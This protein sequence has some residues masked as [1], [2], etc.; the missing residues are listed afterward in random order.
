M[1]FRLLLVLLLVSA[2]ATVLGH[3]AGSTVSD[4]PTPSASRTAAQEAK[5]LILGVAET[6]WSV[7]LDGE[8]ALVG[9]T[10]FSN[11][12]VVA[13]YDRDSGPGQ[14]QLIVG[15]EPSDLGTGRFANS[16]SL[17]GDRALVGAPFNAA[18]GTASGAAYVFERDPVSGLWSQVVQLFSDDIGPGDIFGRS[19]SLLGD[20]ALIGADG[21]GAAYIF[22]R[23]PNTGV[24]SQTDKLVAADATSGDRFGWSV[25]LSGDRALVG[26]FDSIS[27]GN[28]GAAY[29]F[30]RDTGTG[31]WPQSA[32][33]VAGDAGSADR[34]G[35][36]VSL[37]GDR[38]L[39]G[40]YLDDDAGDRSGSAY[41]FDRDAGS[42]LWSQTDKLT[43]NDSAARDEFGYSVSLSGDRALVGAPVDDFS[44]GA[45]YLFG[46]D[47]ATGLWPQSAKLLVADGEFG[48]NFGWS[49]SVSGSRA[50]I[51]AVGDNNDSGSAYI[52]ILPTFSVGGMISGLS[53]SGLMLQNSGVDDLPVTAVGAFTFP[54]L[55][56]D[57]QAYDVSVVSQPT[58][59]NQT[60]SVSNGSGTVAGADV[61]DV[62]IT[63]ITDQFTVSGTVTG[64]ASGN[65]VTLV[66]NGG[67]AQTV[68]GDGPFTFSPQNDGTGFNV[69][70][71]TQPTRPSQAC[72]VT[73]GT[74]TVS[75]ADV[76]DVQVNCVTDQFTV[77]GSVSGLS[78][79]GLILQ[80]NG[81]DDLAITANEP[82]TF[83][84]ALDDGSSYTVS[85]QTQ[86][87]EPDQICTLANDSGVLSGSN[88]TN[89][90]VQCISLS[91]INILPEVLN[92]GDQA[93]GVPT[94]SQMAVVESTGPAELVLGSITLVGPQAADFQITLDACTDTTLPVDDAC[95][96]EVMFTPTA[97]GVR[98]AWINIPSNAPSSLDRVDVIGT[99]DVVFRD[100]FEL[101]SN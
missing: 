50:L 35:W 52:L 57:G 27:I 16:V 28:T 94:A 58:G 30:D 75:G 97:A 46:R 85:V 26:A 21:T 39:V 2:S 12:G 14:W 43:A 96:I 61:T 84:T 29:V 31:L 73:D 32:K 4:A 51:G 64:L 56:A 82:F 13:V 9:G 37:S 100:G 20:R 42:G 74:G 65:S 63:C 5:L 87:S 78:G 54:G 1:K 67:D 99:N 17:D 33:L 71:Q 86:P 25:S 89:V 76:T 70:V 66:N 8:R 47:P 91:G 79:S 7:S 72:T 62:Q 69:T 88:V 68:N 6:G 83:L 98:Q 95:G 10:Q 23:N 53:G 60:C 3:S 44:R 24:W 18:N 55:L 41:V 34:F 59:P 77:G 101:E 81:A 80:N 22:D 92:F 40:A 49:V 38:A 19:V 48:D 45:A 11:R 36:S 90:Q 15:L 93:L